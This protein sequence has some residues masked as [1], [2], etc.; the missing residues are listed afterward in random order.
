MF[1]LVFSDP[2]SEQLYLD[3]FHCFF[4]PF[5]GVIEPYFWEVPSFRFGDV[6]D[7]GLG[8]KILDGMAGRV[9]IEKNQGI[10]GIQLEHLKKDTC[11]F[12][13]FR[14]S[15]VFLSVSHKKSEASRFKMYDIWDFG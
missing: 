4:H 15:F 8:S 13:E 6:Y 7:V 2:F 9:R 1:C 3:G 10:F 12:F 11:I 14:V 5:S